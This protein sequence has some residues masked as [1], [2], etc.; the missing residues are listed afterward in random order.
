LLTGC[1]TKAKGRVLG[2]YGHPRA[3]QQD[4]ERHQEASGDLHGVHWPLHEGGVLQLLHHVRVRRRRL[5][6]QQQQ[7][8]FRQKCLNV[9]TF[10]VCDWTI[11]VK[12]FAKLIF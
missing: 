5:Q 11:E 10:S 1:A 3:F 2:F 4:V 8:K 12:D 6:Q 7:Q 9:F